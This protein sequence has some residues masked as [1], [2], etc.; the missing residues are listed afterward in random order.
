[1]VDAIAMLAS[2]E[3]IF[4]DPVYSG[5]GTAGM[6]GLI[7]KSVLKKGETVIFIQTGGSAAFFAYEHLFS[8][9]RRG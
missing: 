3:G 6:I 4:L 8:K 9:Q 2:E 1:M 5:K 7:G